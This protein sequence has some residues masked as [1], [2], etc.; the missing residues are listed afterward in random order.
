MLFNLVG[1]RFVHLR[2]GLQELVCYTCTSL[3]SFLYDIPCF[4]EVYLV[5][6][7]LLIFF[8]IFIIN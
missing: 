3:L 2:D 5:T 7:D 8:Y 6:F 1:S 4:V